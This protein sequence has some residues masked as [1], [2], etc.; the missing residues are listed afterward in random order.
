[1]PR[2][3]PRSTASRSRREPGFFC[4]RGS[5]SSSRTECRYPSVA[6]RSRRCSG[7]AAVRCRDGRLGAILAASSFLYQLRKNK[8]RFAERYLVHE[9]MG[10]NWEPLCVTRVRAEM[11]T[12]KLAPV[13]SATLIQNFD[14][15]VLGR[16]ARKALAR[17]SD[18]DARELAR[19]FFINQAFRCDVFVR[20]GRR[21]NADQRGRRRKPQRP[22]QRRDLAKHLDCS[23]KRHKA[24]LN[25]ELGFP[26]VHLLAE[27]C[28][29]RLMRLGLN[30]WIRRHRRSWRLRSRGD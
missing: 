16:N 24:C 1:M 11:A 9:L 23:I 18:D 21:L 27:L 25:Q 15:L 19:D 7:G 22:S 13:G 5:A 14:S 4:C 30:P 20:D 12:I 10:E 17:I 28:Q 26:F 8:K 2:A 3:G 29:R 6:A